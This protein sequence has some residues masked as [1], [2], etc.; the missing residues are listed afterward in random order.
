MSTRRCPAPPA[1]GPL[2]LLLLP[3]ATNLFKVVL[4]LH[5][6][7]PML[8]PKQPIATR[9]KVLQLHKHTQTKKMPCTSIWATA[10]SSISTSNYHLL[11]LPLAVLQLYKHTYTLMKMLLLVTAIACKILS[12]SK[13]CCDF[14]S[15]WTNATSNMTH[16]HCIKE[17][18]LHHHLGHFYLRYYYMQQGRKFFKAH[19]QTGTHTHTYTNNTTPG[20]KQGLNF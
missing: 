6:L 7:G 12:F 17:Y 14:A 19:S 9:S 4:W 2:L 18:A 11:L 20:F 10:T 5:T 3:L 15:T 8:P 1:P 13:W 16:T